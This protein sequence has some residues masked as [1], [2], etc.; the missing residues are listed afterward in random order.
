M[1]R[2]SSFYS[3]FL[4]LLCAD[5]TRTQMHADEEMYPWHEPPASIHYF[6]RCFVLTTHVRKCTQMRRCTHSTSPQH[7]FLFSNVALCWPHTYTDA[8]RWGDVPMARAS[9]HCGRQNC[10]GWRPRVEPH[11]WGLLTVRLVIHIFMKDLSEEMLTVRSVIYICMKDLS[12]EMLTVRLL[13]YIFM[14]DLSEEM[15]TVSEEMLAVRKC[16]QWGNAHSECE[17]FTAR[18]AQGEEMRGQCALS[19][20][21]PLWSPTMFRLLTT[22]TSSFSCY[23]ERLLFSHR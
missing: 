1:A 5:H 11:V 3:I 19:A 13:I 16:S 4:T 22:F 18:N 8:R 6:L 2:A 20:T 21:C 9:P 7:L 10:G 17:M 12:E 15:L 14:K 23:A